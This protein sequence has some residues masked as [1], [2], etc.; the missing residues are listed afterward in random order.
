M[1]TGAKG[2]ILVGRMPLHD[3]LKVEAESVLLRG[4]RNPS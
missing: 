3:T 1:G 4:M 2:S